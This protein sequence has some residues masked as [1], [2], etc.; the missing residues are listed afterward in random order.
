MDGIAYADEN[1]KPLRVI[2]VRPLDGYKL[3]LRFSTGETK[4]F[5]FAPLINS[6]GFQLL[7]D[8]AIFNTVYIDYGIPVWND[9]AIDIA[10]EY[11]Y[12]NGV[13]G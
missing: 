12:R 6:S 2:S 8:K 13:S 3:W 5:D 10:P 7:K 11:L 4:V 9:G 1:A